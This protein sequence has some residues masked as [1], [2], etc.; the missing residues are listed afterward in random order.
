MAI[1]TEWWHA[2]PTFFF[3]FLIPPEMAHTLDLSNVEAIS[4]DS[5]TGRDQTTFV[6]KRREKKT[7]LKYSGRTTKC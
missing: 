2:I 5:G 6:V 1:I 4:S 3:F 7:L